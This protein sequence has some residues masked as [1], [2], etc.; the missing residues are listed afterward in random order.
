[1]KRDMKREQRKLKKE[2]MA[3][4]QNF[5]T[6]LLMPI[7][8]SAKEIKQLYQQT[9]DAAKEVKDVLKQLQENPEKFQQNK[10]GVD[11]KLHDYNLYK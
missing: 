1:M 11:Q 10:S 6:D 8:D 3:D 5:I 4:S 2:I 9:Q 7:K